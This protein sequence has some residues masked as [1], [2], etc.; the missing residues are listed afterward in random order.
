MVD[1]ET[2]RNLN[3]AFHSVNAELIKRY[4]ADGSHENDPIYQMWYRTKEAIYKAL[5]NIEMIKMEEKTGDI[6]RWRKEDA[7][8]SV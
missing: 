6:A 4:K 8:A 3:R 1:I 5:F 7:E 2:E